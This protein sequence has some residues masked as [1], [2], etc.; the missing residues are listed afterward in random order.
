MNLE[1]ERV[2]RLDENH[3]SI[4]KFKSPESTSYKA[5]IRAFEIIMESIPGKSDLEGDSALEE[6]MWNLTRR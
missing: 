2:I 3:I 5:V 1:N 6:R 4:C